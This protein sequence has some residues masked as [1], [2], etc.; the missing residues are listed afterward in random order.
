MGPFSADYMA[1]D[2]S[3]KGRVVG[4]DRVAGKAFTFYQGNFSY[5]PSLV[6]GG[7]T[8]ARAVNPCGTIVGSAED[9]EGRWVA[10]RW[11]RRTCD[12]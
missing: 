5:L 8:V 9:G 12:S 7:E 11:S 6:A 3:D 10:V 4:D 2:V 1:E